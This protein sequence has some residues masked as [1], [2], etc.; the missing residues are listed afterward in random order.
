MEAM[1]GRKIPGHHDIKFAGQ[2]LLVL[3]IS[4]TV[5]L[6]GM[7]IFYGVQ[8]ASLPADQNVLPTHTGNPRYITPQWHVADSKGHFGNPRY[9][10]PQEPV[11]DP[12]DT[13]RLI[14]TAMK[15]LGTAGGGFVVLGGSMMALANMR[16]KSKVSDT[17]DLQR[18]PKE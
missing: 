18:H 7:A 11:T 12:K 4:A 2:M 16:I 15:S 1:T 14:E 10:T 3:A 8:K 9:I 6:I 5:T 13:L 17:K